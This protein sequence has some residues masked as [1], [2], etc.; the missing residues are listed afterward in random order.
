MLPEGCILNTDLDIVSS[1]FEEEDDP[2]LEADMRMEV[3]SLIEK[4]MPADGR[5]T[6]NEYVR[7][8]DDL[9]VCME[10]DNDTWEADFMDQL[11]KRRMREG[12]RRMREGKR[13]MKIKWT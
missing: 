8:D 11:L 4:T 10:F 2:F 7:G 12:K 9:L 3:Q 13:M 6:V 5:W 1:G